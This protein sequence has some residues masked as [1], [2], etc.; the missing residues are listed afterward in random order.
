MR[1]VFKDVLGIL[2]IIFCL[3]N[4]VTLK[5]ADAQ[6]D[7]DN[8][9][10]SEIDVLKVEAR[11][12]ILEKAEEL[13]VTINNNIHFAYSGECTQAENFTFLANAAVIPSSARESRDSKKEIAGIFYLKSEECDDFSKG[14]VFTV[15]LK[16]EDGIPVSA[17]LIPSNYIKEPQLELEE[18][19]PESENIPGS[20][21]DFYT[22]KTKKEVLPGLKKEARLISCTWCSSITLTYTNFSGYVIKITLR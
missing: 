16:M 13:G 11:T 21:I 10:F 17:S 20:V 2:A 9:V 3:L 18:A 4:Q 7:P 6:C 12:A 22:F 5:H 8:K 1:A 19:I 15:V 14:V